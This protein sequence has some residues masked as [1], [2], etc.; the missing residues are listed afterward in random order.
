VLDRIEV[1]AE[2]D[3]A[4]VSVQAKDAPVSSRQQI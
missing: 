2:R 4:L 3:P 1:W